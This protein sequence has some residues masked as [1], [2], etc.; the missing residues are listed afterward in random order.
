MQICSKT[1]LIMSMK[2]VKF[3]GGK[4]ASDLFNSI[5]LRE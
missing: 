3:I 2:K 1:Q 4:L 5:I